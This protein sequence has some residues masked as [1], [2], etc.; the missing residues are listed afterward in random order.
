MLEFMS[1]RVLF[2]LTGNI[3]VYR[4]DGVGNSIVRHSN[5]SITKNEQKQLFFFN[6]QFQL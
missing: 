2:I 1:A 5:Q 3:P 6:L 4:K